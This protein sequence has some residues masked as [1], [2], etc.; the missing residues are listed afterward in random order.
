M[1]KLELAIAILAGISLVGFFVLLGIEKDTSLVAPIVT[2]LIS[3]LLGAKKEN[4]ASL[5]KR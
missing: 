4:I 3:F 5:F 2:A 1:T